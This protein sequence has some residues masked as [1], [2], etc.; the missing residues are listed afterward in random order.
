MQCPRCGSPLVGHFFPICLWCG[1]SIL[2]S[3]HLARRCPDPDDPI[4]EDIRACLQKYGVVIEEKNGWVRLSLS[5]PDRGLTDA[6]KALHDG[7]CIGLALAGMK[8]SGQ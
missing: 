8:V 4:S 1:A 3:S 2:S 7:I 5:V 6:E